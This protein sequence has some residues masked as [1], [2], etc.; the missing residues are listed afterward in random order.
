MNVL[1]WCITG[2]L[3]I[4]G[5]AQL[6]EYLILWLCRPK[7]P[8]LRYEIIPLSGS[9]DELELLL[10]YAE[11]SSSASMIL[12]LDQGLSESGKRL[13]R[14]FCEEHSGLRFVT[15]EE[16][17]NLIFTRNPLEPVENP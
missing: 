5:A 6:W 3:L 1:L 11:L 2:F 13:C 7:I 9:T 4:L 14:R 12:L 8:L 17:Q 10:Q 16:A 15:E